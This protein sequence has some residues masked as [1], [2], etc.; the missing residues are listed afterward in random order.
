M[1]LGFRKAFGGSA[2]GRNSKT[3]ISRI[4]ARAPTRSGVSG[5]WPPPCPA[6]AAPG[7]GGSGKGGK[8][9]GRG[10][11]VGLG[12]DRD[13]GGPS[14]RARPPL[15]ADGESSKGPAS[16]SVLT[17][18]LE[19]GASGRFFAEE[20]PT[21]RLWW[22][23]VRRFAFAGGPAACPPAIGI[24]ATAALWVARCAWVVARVAMAAAC[25]VATST[26]FVTAS[27]VFGVFTGPTGPVADACGTA[28]VAWVTAAFTCW[29]TCAV[30]KGSAA[31]AVA[32]IANPQ[33]IAPPTA[34]AMRALRP[35]RSA[36][37]GRSR[38]T[39]SSSRRPIRPIRPLIGAASTRI[40]S[41]V[42][43][44]ATWTSRRRPP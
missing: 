25:L 43:T 29:T 31:C 21:A 38:R 33:A 27:T 13:A 5:P 39:F 42:A 30:P 19:F 23:T 40:V 44:W 18:R 16:R 28:A 12:A 24:D 15:A 37:S 26:L 8:R 7:P 11:R 35:A 1:S 9:C 32:G 34:H 4:A 6:P 10:E 22:A 36:S 14:L 17:S 41:A 3:M 2:R 20:R